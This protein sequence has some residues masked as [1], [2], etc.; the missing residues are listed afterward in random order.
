MTTS[1]AA[2]AA[3]P[4]ENIG[5]SPAAY[6]AGS[7]SVAFV[8]TPD[9]ETARKLA[10]GIVSQKLAACVNIIPKVLSIYVWEG[11]VNEDAELLLM[12]KTKSDKIDKLSK[13]VRENHPYTVAEVISLPIENGNPPYLDWITKT[14]GKANDK[15]EL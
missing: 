5:Q 11:E 14:V 13:Y 12:I 15:T 1:P 10:K 4:T 9:E 3:G 8:T 7:N 2:A 6:I